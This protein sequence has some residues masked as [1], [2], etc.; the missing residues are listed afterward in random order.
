MEVKISVNN[1]FFGA[2]QS[3]HI[4]IINMKK[5]SCNTSALVSSTDK[6]A[7]TG[8]KWHEAR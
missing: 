7:E 8:L 4:I 3:F 6:A 2:Y 1:N 5:S